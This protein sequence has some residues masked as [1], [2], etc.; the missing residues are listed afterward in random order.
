MTERA[1]PRR[2][3]LLL[4]A[5]ALFLPIAIVLIVRRRG[6]NEEDLA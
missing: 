1:G 3:L 6:R 4:L 5:G 2:I